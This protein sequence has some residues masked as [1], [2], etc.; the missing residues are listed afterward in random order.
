MIHETNNA[1]WQNRVI[2]QAYSRNVPDVSLGCILQR[3]FLTSFISRDCHVSRGV[4]TKQK[5]QSS[6]WTLIFLKGQ[7]TFRN[8]DFKINLNLAGIPKNREQLSKKNLVPHLYRSMSHLFFL[9]AFQNLQ[10][11]KGK[12]TWKLQFRMHKCSHKTSLILVGRHFNP[13]CTEKPQYLP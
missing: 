13:R 8:I 10:E 3:L 9:I 6:I 4:D 12:K 11:K 2:R 1:D 7:Q 5:R